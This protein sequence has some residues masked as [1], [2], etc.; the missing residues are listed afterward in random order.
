MFMPGRRPVTMK[1]IATETAG[2]IIRQTGN[3]RFRQQGQE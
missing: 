1:N 2:A 3:R